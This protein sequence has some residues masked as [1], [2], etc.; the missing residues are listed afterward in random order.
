M[1]LQL[2]LTFTD[3]PQSSIHTSFS[4][5]STSYILPLRGQDIGET[6]S[7]SDALGGAVVGCEDGSLYLFHALRSSVRAPSV[8]ALSRK[9]EASNPAS[10]ASS[11]SHTPRHP[12]RHLR[13]SS[14]RSHSPASVKSP[15]FSPFHVT[16]STV[17]SSVSAEQVEAPKNYVDFEDEQEKLKG[18]IKRKGGVKDRTMVDA[19]MPGGDKVKPLGQDKCHDSDS[20]SDE[21]PSK[22]RER[23]T[24][25]KVSTSANL[26][27][28]SS[29]RSLSTPSTPSF[30]PTL[31]LP[32]AS[33]SSH[34]ALISHS[35][36][37]FGG[38]AGAVTSVKHIPGH[39]CSL[40]LC[41]SGYVS[42]SCPALHFIQTCNLESLVCIRQKMEHV[43]R[44][45]LPVKGH[46]HPH[47][48][49]RRSRN[50]PLYGI[51]KPCTSPQSTM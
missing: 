46:S 29:V 43:F 25:L 44:A 36:S 9:R 45:V 22:P 32:D 19:L 28:A 1:T 27:S 17:V 20:S 48:A 7:H 3:D 49:A 34:W 21:S 33:E 5:A 8:E 39:Q 11:T 15:S 30:P 47:R 51:G 24:D 10:T 18:M 2:S 50:Y 12:R 4:Q 14:P 40:A 37:P 35:L 31:R 23:K 38:A 26:S 41:Q 42:A 13:S 6:G 16:K